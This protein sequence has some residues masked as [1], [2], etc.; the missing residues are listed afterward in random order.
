M[1]LGSR[2]VF[3]QKGQICMGEKPQKC[4]EASA[5]FPSSKWVE[6]ESVKKNLIVHSLV[7]TRCDVVGTWSREHQ[8][9]SSPPPDT[10]SDLNM[11]ESTITDHDTFQTY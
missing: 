9:S 3:G 6:N 2:A 5:S 11:G 8:L 10:M 7:F 1:S 4:G